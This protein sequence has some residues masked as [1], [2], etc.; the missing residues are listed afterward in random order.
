[1]FLLKSSSL[2]QKTRQIESE[3]GLKTKVD[4]KSL[5]RSLSFSLFLFLYFRYVG[6]GISTN[7]IDGGGYKSYAIRDALKKCVS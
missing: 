4:I 3:E 5:K 2:F 6:N 1:M 7:I